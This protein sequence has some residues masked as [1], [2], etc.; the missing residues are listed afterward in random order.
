MTDKQPPDDLEHGQRPGGQRPP[1]SKRD[2][3]PD[4]LTEDGNPITLEDGNKRTDDQEA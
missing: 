3:D 1:P 4:P 2:R